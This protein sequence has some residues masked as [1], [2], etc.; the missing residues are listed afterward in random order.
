MDWRSLNA[1]STWGVSR[2]R[3]NCVHSQAAQGS[4]A[5]SGLTD[6]RYRVP[7][8]RAL[9]MGYAGSAG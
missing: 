4:G 3:A 1:T 7:R 9:R 6:T 5:G 8:I 2:L